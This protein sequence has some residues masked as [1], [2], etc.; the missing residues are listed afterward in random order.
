VFVAAG[1]VAVQ[2]APSA[3][4]NISGKI[5]ELDG[6]PIAGATV[7]LTKAG[8]TATTDNAGAFTLNSA[9][10]VFGGEAGQ[11]QFTPLRNGHVEIRIA[12]SAPVTVTAF[13]PGG[14]I[15]DKKKRFLEAGTHTVP[16]SAARPGV[17]IFKVT[18]G[19]RT[20]YFK[21]CSL[22]G[23]IWLTTPGSRI[24]N[25]ALAKSA[26]AYGPHF[27]A[28]T[29]VVSKTGYLDYV[30][31]I[32]S[33][34]TSGLS[35]RMAKSD[36]PVFSRQHIFEPGSADFRSCHSAGVIELSDGTLLS[37]YFGG[38]RESA[39]DVEIRMNRK[40]PGGKWEPPVSVAKGMVNGSKT[41]TGNPSL[42]QERGGRLFLFYFAIP[43]RLLGKM[44]TSMDGG[45]TW[46]ESRTICGGKCLAPEKNK[47]VQ[48]ENGTILGPTAD[49][50]GNFPGGKLMVIRSKDGGET[51][52][53]L[54][55]V[56]D[57]EA[58]ANDPIQPAIMILKDGRLLMMSRHSGGKIPITWSTDNGETWAPL[59]QSVL[60]ANSSG[61]DGVTLRDG[62]V[63]FVYNHVPTKWD[64]K[65]PRN[66]LNLAVSKDDGKTWGAG[67]VLGICSG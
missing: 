51:W 47:A 62:R 64:G 22:D 4:I 41:S 57:G 9:S 16:L 17:N 55:G 34:D 46:S 29:V 19:G 56:D 65:G 45:K 18:A 33:T 52:E 28:D 36:H 2:G 24:P 38:S 40:S 3:K 15:L 37:V 67:L 42:F 39:K 48:L 61:V 8:Q 1:F 50:N 54:P 12:E 35:F 58:M 5:L 21:G 13:S 60:P 20:V 14:K 59:K 49:R 11:P 10:A 53:G 32:M 31:G 23:N 43:G 30:S 63:F 26:S 44:K 25:P 66:F 7:K 27:F 6:T